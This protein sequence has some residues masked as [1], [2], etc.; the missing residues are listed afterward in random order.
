MQYRRTV[1][2]Q[3]SSYKKYLTIIIREKLKNQQNGLS[4]VWKWLTTELSLSA[5]YE[6]KQ[7]HIFVYDT[8]VWEDKVNEIARGNKLWR[9]RASRVEKGS[10]QQLKTKNKKN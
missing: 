7:K 6:M 9:G 1:L 4:C 2:F 3:K 5:G 10:E 8:E